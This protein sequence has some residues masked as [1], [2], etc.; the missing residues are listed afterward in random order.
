MVKMQQLVR[1]TCLEV[2]QGPPSQIDAYRREVIELQELVKGYLQEVRELRRQAP[3]S[4]PSTA[5]LH[6]SSAPGSPGPL[7]VLDASFEEEPQAAW[8]EHKPLPRFA[9]QLRLP[10]G[11]LY[12]H[13]DDTHAVATSAAAANVIGLA[14]APR[15]RIAVGGA[16]WH[17]PPALD[18]HV[19]QP[20]PVVGA[21]PRSRPTRG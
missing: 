15:V 12:P 13:A 10:T 4:S 17:V 11:E 8:Y 19:R 2:M 5:S 3:P 1:V 14:G 18:H 7:T 9:V 21:L 20:N 16:A 6:S